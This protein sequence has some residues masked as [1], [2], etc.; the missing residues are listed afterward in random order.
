MLYL[1]KIILMLPLMFPNIPTIFPTIFPFLLSPFSL[2]L[3]FHHREIRSPSFLIFPIFLIFPFIFLWHQIIF[4][5]TKSCDLSCD[6]YFIFQVQVLLALV[7]YLDN[8]LYFHYIS[9]IIST[10]I[11]H[12]LSDSYFHYFL[13][14]TIPEL[15]RQST[16]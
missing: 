7:Y 5:I 16:I 12:H 3:F 9:L 2:F 6:L 15:L 14:K 1:Y 10:I 13:N 8:L 11:Y 4:C